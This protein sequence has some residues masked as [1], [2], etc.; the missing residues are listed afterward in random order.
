MDTPCIVSLQSPCH[1][2]S[3]NDLVIGSS[4]PV[5]KSVKKIP[6]KI[7][8]LLLAMRKKTEARRI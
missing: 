6:V 4:I 1:R 8:V 5:T 3:S 7:V 2:L